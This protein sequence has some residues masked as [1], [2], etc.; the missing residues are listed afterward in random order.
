MFDYPFTTSQHPSLNDNHE[1]LLCRD[2]ALPI[3]A[4]LSMQAITS[5]RL[6]PFFSTRMSLNLHFND[7]VV[8]ACQT[9]REPTRLVVGCTIKLYQKGYSN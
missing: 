8:L 2:N 4:F 7:S 9:S 6:A 5:C 3:I 1:D